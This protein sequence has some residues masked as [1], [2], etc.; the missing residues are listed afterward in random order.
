MGQINI[1]GTRAVQLKGYT[2]QAITSD[3]A[4]TFPDTGGE[5]ATNSSGGG[6]VVGY[7]QGTWIPSFGSTGSEGT[8][9]YS[10]REGYYSRIGNTVTLQ[11]VLGCDTGTGGGNGNLKLTNL[12]YVTASRAGG[13]RG[14]GQCYSTGFASDNPNFLLLTNNSTEGRF[15]YYSNTNGESVSL[16]TTNLEAGA[17]IYQTITYQT[18]DTT[19]APINGATI[20]Q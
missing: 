19:W 9:V 11:C 7:Q 20:T 1:G 10:A 5:L 6:Q 14:V 12:P 15:Y 16:E 13:G 2:D 18:T 4:F 8:Y 3:Q 17:A